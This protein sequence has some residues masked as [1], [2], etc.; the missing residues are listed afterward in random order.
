VN[1]TSVTVNGATTTFTYTYQVIDGL[2]L[3]G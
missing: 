3:G 1:L 2:P